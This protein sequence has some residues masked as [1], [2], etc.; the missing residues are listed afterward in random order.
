MSLAHLRVSLGVF[1]LAL[2]GAWRQPTRAD[3]LY[4]SIDGNN[5]I[6]KITPA[7]V[8]SSYAAAGGLVNPAGIAFDGAG[9]LYA[10]NHHAGPQV[11]PIDTITKIPPGGG[12][13][14]GSVFANGLGHPVGIAFDSMGDLYVTEDSFVGIVKLTSDGIASAFPNIGVLPGGLAFD[15]A[16]NLYVADQGSNQ[17]VEYTPNFDVRSV[18]ASSGLDRPE[19]L[20]FDSA[21]NLYVANSAS[22]TIEKF[23]PDGVGSVFA[24][25]GLNLP[26]GLA[27]DSAGNLYAVNQEDHNIERFT[28]DGLGSVFASGL[29]GPQYLAFTDDAGVPLPL[30]IPEPGF[31]G[32]VAMGLLTVCAPRK[33]RRTIRKRVLAQNP[34]L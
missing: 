29:N 25:S 12:L 21:G 4:V 20:A 34:I 23:T 33:W 26:L 18:F 5:S 32:L 2:G 30:P 9:N 19:G 16:G 3:I 24:S 14:A 10:A 28:P 27:F 13:G 11:M 22:N 31:L 8:G 15:R 6:R 1:T 7:G 17:I